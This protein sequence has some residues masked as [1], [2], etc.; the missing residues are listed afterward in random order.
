M[1]FLRVPY[2]CTSSLS[3]NR[4]RLALETYSSMALCELCELC[5]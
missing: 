3:M 2:P 1:V 4:G 5:A